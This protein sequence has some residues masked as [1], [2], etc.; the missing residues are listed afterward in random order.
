MRSLPF[1]TLALG[2]VRAHHGRLVVTGHGLSTKWIPVDKDPRISKLLEPVLPSS[3]IDNQSDSDCYR[4]AAGHVELLEELLFESGEQY[5]I[6]VQ[7]RLD[8]SLRV[9]DGAHRAMMMAATS[10]QSLKSRAQVWLVI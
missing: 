1:I 7:L 10:K 6:W 8:G 4:E 2:E 3:N 9:V 5:Q